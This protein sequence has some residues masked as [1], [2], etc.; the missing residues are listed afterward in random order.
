MEKDLIVELLE[1]PET[2]WSVS[3]IAQIMSGV[4]MGKLQDKLG[5]YVHAGKLQRLRRG[6]YAKRKFDPYELANK[7]YTPSYVSLESVL[8][9]VGVIFQYYE[10]IF[11]VTS[12]TKKI[13]V[14]EVNIQYRYIKPEVLTNLSGI[15][16]VNEHS[17]ATTERAW[18][19]SVYLYRDYHFDHLDVLDWDKIWGIMPIYGSKA[20]EKRVRAYYQTYLEEK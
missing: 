15:I 1:R 2:V 6:I 12:V 9:K 20:F 17:E 5:Y 14:G 10:T 19:D 13:Q 11:L 4:E 18:L 3:Q 16:Q 7:L 8:V